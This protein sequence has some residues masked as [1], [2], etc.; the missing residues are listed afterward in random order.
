MVLDKVAIR[1]NFV[2][3]Y[4]ITDFVKI[5]TEIDDYEKQIYILIQL[6]LRDYVG[7]YRLDEIL[8][9]KDQIS[10][11]CLKRL[12]EQEAEYF[13]SFSEAG[14]KDIILPGEIRSIMNTVLIAEKSI[15]KCNHTS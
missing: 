9:N 11:I 12:K 5:Y 1:I 14:V 7:K 3:N 8:E 15:G 4:K 10:K 6:A 2:C 13:V